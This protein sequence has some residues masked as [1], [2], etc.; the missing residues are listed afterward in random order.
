MSLSPSAHVDTFTRDNLPPVDQWPDLVFDLPELQYPDRL[1][2][3]EE[4][5]GGSIAR[6]GPHR[7]CLRDASGTVWSYGEG[8]ER[9]DKVAP[10]LADELRIQASKRVLLAPPY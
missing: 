1:N 3:A 6:V 10:V 2:C 7:P 4:L 5:L 9:V 8:G